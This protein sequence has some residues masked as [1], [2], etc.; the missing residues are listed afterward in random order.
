MEDAQQGPHVARGAWPA[1][2]TA[3]LFTLLIA[4]SL[5]EQNLRFNDVQ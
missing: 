2:V 3:R 1:C 5:H 4:V